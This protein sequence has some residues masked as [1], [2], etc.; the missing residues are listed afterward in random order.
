[1]RKAIHDDINEEY[2][3]AKIKA[4][5]KMEIPIAKG[6]IDSIIEVEVITRRVVRIIIRDIL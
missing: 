1:M 6:V 4:I 3:M 5:I 2:M